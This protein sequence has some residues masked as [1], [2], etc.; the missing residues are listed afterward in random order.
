M[1]TEHLIQAVA[2]LAAG[3]A[4]A[5]TTHFLSRRRWRNSRD[6]HDTWFPEFPDVPENPDL[7]RQ[8]AVGAI[9]S[10]NNGFPINVLDPH[11]SRAEM[12]AWL[13][14]SWDANNAEQ[15]RERIQS[16]LMHGH[17][18]TF[19]MLISVAAQ[20]DPDAMREHLQNA[21][22]AELENDPELA[23]FI[24]NQPEALARL[25]KLGYLVTPADVGRGTRAYD[26]GRAVTVSRV[27]F[28]AGYLKRDEALALVRMSAF[29][30]ARTF[31]SWRQFATSYLLGRALWGGVDDPDFEGMV[32]I[33]EELLRNARSPWLRHGWFTQTER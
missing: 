27:A 10:E 7:M 13:S 23:E 8:L 4:L 11:K 29:I 20:G 25:E 15:T 14:G 3:F 9:L 33:T 1:N 24:A 17:A 31:G 18:E 30:A 5:A 32:R 21:F 28:G 16:L 6:R 12:R 2:G 26:L 19:D 22:A